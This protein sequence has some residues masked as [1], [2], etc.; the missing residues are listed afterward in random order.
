VTKEEIH[1]IEIKNP[2]FKIKRVDLEVDGEYYYIQANS[3]GLYKYAQELTEAA[4]QI[5]QDTESTRIDL[6]TEPWVDGDVQIG[7]VEVVR[8][9]KSI[10]ALMN[11]KESNLK[12]NFIKYGCISVFLLL[13]IST[14]VGVATI[15]KWL[16]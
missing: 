15:I 12:D 1:N 3:G 7:Y 8:N 11:D 2:V 10:E 6:P 4:D 16:I 13:I 5:E 9:E 14:C